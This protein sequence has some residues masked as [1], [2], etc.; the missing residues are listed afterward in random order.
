MGRREKE[1]INIAI[2]NLEAETQARVTAQI[3]EKDVDK[4][5]KIDEYINVF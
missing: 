4:F 1:V 2:K 3:F 5:I